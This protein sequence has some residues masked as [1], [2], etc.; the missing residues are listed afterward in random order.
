MTS[1][2]AFGDLSGDGTPNYMQSTAGALTLTASLD[3]AGQA[4]LIHVYDQAWDPSD[5]TTLSGF[6]T[7]QEGFPF[8]NS[9]V[10]TSLTD[11]NTASMIASNDSYWIHARGPDGTEAPGFPKWTGQWTSFGGVVGDPKLDRQQY[12]AYGSREG[13]LFLWKVGGSPNKNDEWWHYRHDEHNSGSYGRDTRPPAGVK[14]VV[15]K[16]SKKKAL[17]TW[18]APGNNGVSN[19]KVAG[20]EVYVSR[21]PIKLS[22]LKAKGVKRVRSPKI[23]RPFGKQSVLVKAKGRKKLYVAVRSRDATGNYSTMSLKTVKPKKL[24]KHHKKK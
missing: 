7:D 20:Y 5:G 3:I 11:D 6:P 15:K 19:G 23:A 22:K 17:L 8:F 10:V 21:K 13:Q 9:P 1:Q 4:S 2:G 14:I 16:R 18:R 12:L 24:K